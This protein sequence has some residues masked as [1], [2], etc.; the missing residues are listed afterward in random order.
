MAVV[1]I[2]TWSNTARAYDL[3]VDIEDIPMQGPLNKPGYIEEKWGSIDN[4]R[5]G[6]ALINLD[7]NNFEH[8]T[9]ATSGATTGDWFI[10]FGAPWCEHCDDMM[11]MWNATAKDLKGEINVGYIDA[12]NNPF[13]AQRFNISGYPTLILV[14][15][16][17]AYEHKGSRY[18][19]DLVRF[20]RLEWE[21]V[22]SFEIP[23]AHGTFDEFV[24]NVQKYTGDLFE[25]YETRPVLFFASIFFGVVFGCVLPYGYVLSAPMDPDFVI[26]KRGVKFEGPKVWAGEETLESIKEESE[27]MSDTLNDSATEVDITNKATEKSSTAPT[28]VPMETVAATS[29]S[30]PSSRKSHKKKN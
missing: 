4:W 29:A 24:Y 6:E 22:D 1:V 8:H 17:R 12:S 28:D 11:Q 3:Q 27:S 23:P 16:G 7:D 20:A 15:Q 25:L 9:Q 26:A 10:M 5:K 21:Q 18:W 30:K 14:R 2:S 19:K 13:T